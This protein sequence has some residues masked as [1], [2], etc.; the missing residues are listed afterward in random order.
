M[1]HLVITPYGMLRLLHEQPYALYSDRTYQPN[2][3]DAAYMNRR[4]TN[5][6]LTLHF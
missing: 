4:Y 3:L 5:L 6:I 1:R 2:D